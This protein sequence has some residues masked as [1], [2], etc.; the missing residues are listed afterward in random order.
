MNRRRTRHA[1]R[2]RASI[3]LLVLVAII[4]L[5][6]CS[7]AATPAPATLGPTA[8]PATQAATAAPATAAPATA[9]PATEAPTTAPTQAAAPGTLELWLG[10][11]LTTATD[12]TDYR[13]WVDNTIAR[14]KAA[15]A[16]WEVN[17]S[18]LPPNND[19]LAAQV[20]A[21][22]ASKKVP[23]V[24]MLYGGSY[25]SAY[26]GG[27][28]R[29]ND[30][31]NKT[32]GFWDSLTLWEWGCMGLDCKG[33]SGEIIGVPVDQYAFI[34]WYRKDLLEQAGVTPPPSDPMANPWTWDQYLAA[35]DKLKAAGIT[36]MVYGDRDG[37]TSSNMLT[38]NVVSYFEEGDQAKFISGE[39]KFTDPK[40]VDAL[41]GIITLKEHGCIPADASTREQLDAAQ[42][43]V[44]GKAA[45]MEGQ[46]QFM[47]YFKDIRDKLG[48]AL[49]PMT[50]SGPFKNDTS[51][52][53]GDTWV[54][55]KDSKNPDQAWQFITLASDETAGKEMMPMLGSPP[56]NKAAAA[57]VD[58]PVVKFALGA[59]DKR[60]MGILDVIMSQATALVWY[61]ELQQAFSGAKTPE[62]ALQAVEDFRAQE[63]P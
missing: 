54:I 1:E 36:P 53:A 32:P 6:G 28:M 20:Q 44:A 17:V 12:G 24:M 41:K 4:G 15:N 56:A 31:V 19:Q 10:G 21:A 8:A 22:F 60:K 26:E 50:G 2:G 58:D 11:I 23:D 14:F 13:K 34:L 9:A 5:T 3:A 63:A 51:A 37:Y 35:C 59:V 49:I 52:M 16:G 7:S 55:P 29:L 62:A 48:V 27:L 42:D 25:T 43:L 46:P 33:G 45:F 40:I 47:P 61:R 39:L 30:Y 38:T 18:L 57:T